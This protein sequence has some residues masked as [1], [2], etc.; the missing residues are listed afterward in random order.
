MHAELREAYWKTR[1]AIQAWSWAVRYRLLKAV[2]RM[3][4]MPTR[5]AGIHGIVRVEH[6]D[7]FSRLLWGEVGHNI[8]HDEGEEWLLDVAFTET[9]SVPAAFYI[10]LDNRGSL[11]E[12]DALTDLSGEPSG[13]GY[14]RKAV[15]SDDTDWTVSQDSGDY[16]ALSKTVTFTASGGSIGPVT[17][18][19]LCTVATGTSGVLINS[20]ALSQER[21]LASGESLNVSM[22]LKASE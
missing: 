3:L 18:G 2:R 21:T 10:G 6:R 8:F 7:R 5:R 15:N 13:N 12:G 1:M 17:K 19:F 14:A 22:A 16:Q 4:G 9:A 11:A 20:K